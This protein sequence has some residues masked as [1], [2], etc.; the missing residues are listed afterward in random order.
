MKK[1]KNKRLIYTTVLTTLLLVAIAI[2]LVFGLI[3]LISSI[4]PFYETK[5]RTE[6]IKT[7]NK[8]HENTKAV[9]WVRVQGTNIDYPV[10]Y[11]TGNADISRITDDFTWVMN[12]VDKI[13]NYV[14]I[15]G[16]NIRNVSSNP[17]ITDKS[18][19]RFEQLPSFMY[20]SFAK[21]N[22]Y[23]QYTVDG[24]DYL[25]KIFS[26]SMAKHDELSYATEDLSKTE[27]KKYISKSLKDSFYDY[28]VDVDE[29]DKILTLS[30]CTRFYGATN[31]YVFKIDARMVRD[32][33]NVKNYSIKGNKNYKAIKEI[34]EGGEKNEEKI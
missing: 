25:Y 7:Y 12:D 1:R 19:T 18:H 2:L 21:D 5:E 6:K 14:Y 4:K 32:K 17:L 29:N 15:I 13:T 11:V 33:E 26:V 10:I 20:L 27:L 31:K 9:G 28:D 8:T 22:K 3:R 16:H 30:T 34:M 23:I 24:K